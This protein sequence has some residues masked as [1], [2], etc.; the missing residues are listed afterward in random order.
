MDTLIERCA[1]LD[2][3]KTTV[4]ACLQLPPGEISKKHTQHRFG[5]TTAELTALADWLAGHGVTHVAMEATGV[6]WKPVYYLL[7]DRFECCWS[8]PR[9]SRTS[10]AARPTP[11]TPPRSP[12][13]SRT[14]CCDLVSCR[15]SRSAA[16][17]PD[18]FELRD[19]AA[20]TNGSPTRATS[21]CSAPSAR[22]C[23]SRPARSGSGRCGPRPA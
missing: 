23:W 3:H 7:E 5:T 10:R 4:T 14:G 12:T 15:P 21:R 11:M 16:A 17:G 22:R 20:I 18:P 6:Y 9:T 1:G 8:T 19:R 13:Y 2:V